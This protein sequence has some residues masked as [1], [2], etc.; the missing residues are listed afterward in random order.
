[1]VQGESET[2]PKAEELCSQFLCNVLL[3][4]FS[5]YSTLLFFHVLY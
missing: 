4:I 5:H 3:F 2:Y 1:M